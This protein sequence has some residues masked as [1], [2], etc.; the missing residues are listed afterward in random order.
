MRKA[1]YYIYRNLN[2]PG[3]FSVKHRGKVVA[4]L[5]SF[6]VPYAE[7]R[8]SNAGHKRAVDE[9]QRNVHAY[10]VVDD[11]PKQGVIPFDYTYRIITYNPY[12]LKTFIYKDTAIPV[13][14]AE[15]LIFEDGRV[16]HLS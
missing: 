5:N 1:K 13:T 15:N 9:M 3:Y 11:L 8:V 6:F 10:A 7:F 14:E 16:Y 2:K 4:H 12:G